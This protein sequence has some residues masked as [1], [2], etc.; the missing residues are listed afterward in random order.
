M[1]QMSRIYQTLQ[2]L[3]TFL[4]DYHEEHLKIEKTE[5][6]QHR[7]EGLVH[8]FVAECNVLE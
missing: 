2:M 5:R 4:A 1:A 8:V 7:R 6:K 3:S